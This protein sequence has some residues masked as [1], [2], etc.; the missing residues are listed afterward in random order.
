MELKRIK[1]KKVADEVI[2]Q[3]EELV[4]GGYLKPG[5]KL[6]S[7]RELAEKFGVSR[8]GIR[9]ALSAL[10]VIGFVEVKSGEGTFIR[11]TSKD[12]NMKAL[13]LLLLLEKDSMEDVFE[14]RKILEVAAVKYAA[15]RATEDN[16]SMMDK[17]LNYMKTDLEDGKF[18]FDPDFQFHY[19][20]AESSG[21]PLLCRLMNTISGSV[22]QFLRES[23]PIRYTSI[24]EGN[25]ILNEHIKIFKA[26]MNK[27]VESAGRFMEDHLLSASRKVFNDDLEE[28]I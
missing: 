5:S 7:E 23:W 26:I 14:I 22:K 28:K 11:E 13:S 12:S 24:E 18:S 8:G 16:L 6:P 2:K 19:S 21:N 9:E 15:E 10:D 3:I 4:V 20:I 27:D 17:Y 1:I 25:K